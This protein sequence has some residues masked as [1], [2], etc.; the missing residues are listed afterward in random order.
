MTETRIAGRA[1]A[2]L[3]VVGAAAATVAAYLVFLGWHQEKELD[4]ATGRESGP[5]QPW[6]VIAL[7]LV[8]GLLAFAAGRAGRH[9]LVAPVI[10][11]A[12]TGCFALNAATEPDSD[13]LWVIGAFLVAVGSLTGAMLV[14]VVG[15]R[16][17]RR[18]AGGR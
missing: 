11:V 16:L 13:G 1:P 8:L 4:P 9:W 5:Y 6:Q 12:L 2:V 15:S 10:A 7:V 3:W 14:G 18:R 17:G